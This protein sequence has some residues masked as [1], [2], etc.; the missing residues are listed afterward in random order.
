MNVLLADDEKAIAVTLGDALRNAG[1]EV[2][3]VNDG[4]S[5]APRGRT[6][7]PRSSSSRASRPSSP[8]SRP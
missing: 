2:T 5:A 8:L 4:T 6:R 7:A 3:V 1:H